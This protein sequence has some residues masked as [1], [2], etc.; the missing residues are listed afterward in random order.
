MT[1]QELLSV[2]R[3][4]DIGDVYKEA[5]TDAINCIADEA[6]D[7]GYNDGHDDCSMEDLPESVEKEVERLRK[8]AF[9]N[10]YN[11]GFRDGVKCMQHQH[12]LSD[13]PLDKVCSDE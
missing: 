9:A 8:R 10:G 3:S 13:T 7:E 11:I 2:I 12:N 6:Y 5:L 1:Y 4:M